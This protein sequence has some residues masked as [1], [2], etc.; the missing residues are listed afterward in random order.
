[1]NISWLGL[2][3]FELKTKTDYGEV[4]MV[5]DPYDNSTGLRF[6]R[7]LEAQ[8]VAV[9]HDAH[10]ANNLSQIGGEPFR[11]TTPGEFEVK[12]VFIYGISAPR[13]AD[14]TKEDPKE[15]LIFRFEIE[16]M[17]VAHLGALD[18]ELTD[19]ELAGLENIDILMLPVGGN[20]VMT[21][22]I[23]TKVISQI[24]PR[25]VIP[26]THGIPNVKEKLGSINDF[27]KELG[28][29]RR[30]DSSKLKIAKKDLPD[31]DMLMVVLER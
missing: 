19:E 25:V 18:R 4:V 31:E 9:S 15:N 22:K 11:I 21:P 10:H 8:V 1:M 29:C 28:T 3:C 14:K 6:P 26:M 13:K 20:R 24:E 2:S 27:C 12:G 17:S 7:T 23:A 5:V 16:E 30:E